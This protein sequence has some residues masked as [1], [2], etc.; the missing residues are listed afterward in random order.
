MVADLR[1]RNERRYTANGI[2]PMLMRDADIKKAPEQWPSPLPVP[3]ASSSS[4][5]A[6]L[7]GL[8]AAT[9][10]PLPLPHFSL[11]VTFEQRVYDSLLSSLTQ[12]MSWQQRICHVV[13]LHTTDNT[14]EATVSAALVSE[15]IGWLVSSGEDW[16]LHLDSSISR[17]ETQF[18]RQLLHST[19]WY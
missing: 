13:N 3:P 18:G 16:E 11:I 10:S 17:F 4:S 7:P 19:W 15:W 8:P 6:P 12:R 5:S 1:R 9:P 2:L 14:S